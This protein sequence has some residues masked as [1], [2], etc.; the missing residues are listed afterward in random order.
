MG[1]DLTC[2]CLRDKLHVDLIIS[3]LHP[4]L[5]LLPVNIRRVEYCLEKQTGLCAWA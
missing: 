5:I 4:L 1:Y 2:A 3:A